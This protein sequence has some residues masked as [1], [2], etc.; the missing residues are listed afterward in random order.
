MTRSRTSLAVH[1]GY[2]YYTVYWWSGGHWAVLT[3]VYNA[4]NPPS[5][6]GTGSCFDELHPYPYLI[7][8]PL[9]VDKKRMVAVHLNGKTKVFKNLLGDLYYIQYTGYCVVRSTTSGGIP[10]L[11][12]A[13]M[14]YWKTKALA[15]LNLN[16]PSV[17]IPLN[18]FEF[19]D[20]PRMLK[21]LG[22][23]LNGKIK[24]TDIPNGHLAYQ[25]GWKPLFNDLV[26]LLNLADDIQRRKLQL[27]KAMN[28]GGLRMERSLGSF[29][30]PRMFY[31]E[32]YM[33]EKPVGSLPNMFSANASWD[34]YEKA[35]F[36]ARI[37][38]IPSKLPS[39]NLE[40]IAARAALGLNFSAGTIW[41]MLPWSWLIDYFSNVGDVLN[42][43]RGFIPHTV[44]HLNVMVYQEYRRSLS[45]VSSE[46]SYTGGTGKV[47]R[48]NRSQPSL[49]PRLVFKPFLTNGHKAILGSLIVAKA[50]K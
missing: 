8:G 17:D 1:P 21:D 3:T 13:S 42:A 11:P 15:N 28:K 47:T 20:F 43:G 19:K 36:S 25:F 16:K 30:L 5:A 23:V 40:T 9:I 31:G 49:V 34:G 26:Q 10:A 39:G 2:G 32:P 12:A 24:P 35:W 45:K 6:V 41:E 22:R 38:V 27:M 44:T 18:I 48:K 50:L 33:F 46:C 14:N 37:A 7:D 4:D 29:D